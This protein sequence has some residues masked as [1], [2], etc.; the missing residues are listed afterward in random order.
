MTTA[1]P[2]PHVPIHSD[3]LCEQIEPLLGAAASPAT[4]VNWGGDE[5]V[6]VVDWCEQAELLSGRKAEF[7]LQPVPGSQCGAVLDTRRRQ[8]LTGPCRREFR[9]E[10]ETLF[11][12]RHTGAGG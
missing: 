5:V 12:A 10:F 8:A 2:Y 9:R 3:D 1:L 7:Q 4:L 11:R 6:T